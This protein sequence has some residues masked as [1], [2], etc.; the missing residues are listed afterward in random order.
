MALR[1][2]DLNPLVFWLLEAINESVVAH[3]LSTVEEIKCHLFGYV[4]HVTP[5]A[6]RKVGANF[7]IFINQG[8]PQLRW[9]T[10]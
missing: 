6:L 1:N 5:E 10:H 7:A 3:S 4:Q 9:L 2:L 8:L